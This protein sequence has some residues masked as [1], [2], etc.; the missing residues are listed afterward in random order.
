MAVRESTGGK[1]VTFP[2]GEFSPESLSEAL[3]ASPAEV[4]IVGEESL[5]PGDYSSKLAEQGV[6]V[7]ELVGKD[8]F[9][10]SDLVGEWLSKN[11][12]EWRGAYIVSGWN[13][14]AIVHI[15]QD[16]PGAV[17]L[18]VNPYHDLVNAIS[19]KTGLT[20]KM[21]SAGGTSYGR[22]VYIDPT[23]FNGSLPCNCT[24]MDLDIE[25]TAS[26]SLERLE[27][28]S[29]AVSDSDLRARLDERIRSAKELMS[30][31]EY[32]EA[33]GIIE[34]CLSLSYSEVKES[35]SPGPAKTSS[36]S[37]N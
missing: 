27:N 28:L 20:S 18:L 37:S 15:I 26:L 9:E 34:K 11:A 19:E 24:P 4:I 8:R 7:T 30:E 6:K 25:E 21:A 23:L 2:M 35:I 14:G 36:G 17:V 29:G 13:D 32:L 16:D 33:E 1:L 31:G 5:V 22:T 3:S 12:K 10:T